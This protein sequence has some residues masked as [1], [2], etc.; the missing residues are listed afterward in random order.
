MTELERGVARAPG[1]TTRPGVALSGTVL[2]AIAAALSS[3]VVL[4]DE[5]PWLA[6]TLITVVAVIAAGLVV[7]WRVRTWR[8]LW[9]VVAALAAW[10]LSLQLQF[11][12]DTAL[13]GVVPLAGTLERATELIAAGELSIAE[14]G[15]PAEADVG[16]RFLMAAGVGLL[17][18]LVDATASLSRRPAATA[19]PL[20]GILA[21]PV[22]LVPGQVPTVSLLATGAAF[23]L[24]LAV[25]RPSASGGPAAA[26]RA[27]AIGASMLIGALV[28]P[29]LMPTV[30]AGSVLP[31]GGVAGL[32]AGINPVLDLGDDLRR[33]SPVTVLRYTND[34]AGGQY[35]TLAHL[36]EFTGQNVQPVTTGEEGSIEQIGPP[37]WLGD[38]VERTDVSTRIALED[39]RT[40]WLPLP[41][42]PVAVEGVAGE[43]LIEP[44]GV[45]AQTREGVLR[46]GV[47]TVQSLEAQP[48]AEQL[49]A[50]SVQAPGLDEFREVPELDP[51]IAATAQ[52]VVDA[53]DA[54]S[55]YAQAV[56][57]QR[58][59][60]GG[61]FLYSEDAPVEGGYDGSGADIVATFLEVRAGYC[62]HF[63]SAMTLMARTLGMPARI[64]VGF[65]PGVENPDAPGEYVVSSNDLHAWP[66]VHFD[67]LGWVRFE[68]TPTRGTLPAYTDPAVS[69]GEAGDPEEAEF[70][71]SEPNEVTGEP[72][73][74]PE[75]DDSD[76]GP[77]GIPD[78]LEGEA[79]EGGPDAAAPGSALVDARVIALVALTMLVALLVGPGVWR[80]ARRARRRRSSDPL[81]RWRE[82]RDTARDLG[83]P[84][85]ATR[86]PRALA[87]L[88]EESAWGADASST[89][90]ALVRRA[91]E[92]RA[93]AAPVAVIE[94][95]PIDAVLRRLRRSARWWWRATAVVAPLS[96]RDRQHREERL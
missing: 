16:I 44:D 77:T 66:E 6:S 49:A 68:P 89:E 80:A 36:D 32:S 86:T 25:H 52:N 58:F 55:P 78:L 12:A 31:G 88:W 3:F 39:V 46:D 7:R 33:P 13:L 74:V 79:T 17:A 75:G 93:Y 92:A 10:A 91:V 65:Q 96:L 71:E 27:V 8:P 2:L 95:P 83:L 59:F 69:P 30:V 84:A 82:V 51:T 26:A 24:L 50:A 47:Y 61:D 20:L 76:E 63:A 85:D 70:E 60:T 9:S 90:L 87:A 62:V 48:R 1:S 22:I 38:A 14:Q 53:A 29:P 11:A 19:I 41:S 28:V 40:R 43:W 21:I 64:A 42:A 57:L 35:L 15:I 5:G 67:G 54:E 18:L 56:A 73:A 94:P 34:S 23:L 4:F 72:D 45:T 37:A 81:D